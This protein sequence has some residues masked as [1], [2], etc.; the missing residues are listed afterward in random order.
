MAA[1]EYNKR[2][3]NAFSA[4]V[5]KITLIRS[6]YAILSHGSQKLSK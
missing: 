3:P 6:I 4:D 1:Q 2:S 5:D